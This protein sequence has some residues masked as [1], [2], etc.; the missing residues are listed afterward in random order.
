M[1]G[2]RISEVGGSDRSGTQQRVWERQKK[3]VVIG[4]ISTEENYTYNCFFPWGQCLCNI[5]L[6]NG[7]TCVESFKI[8]RVKIGSLGDEIPQKLTHICNYT[9]GA[10]MF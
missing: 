5:S 2:T 9:T 8:W 4:L 10:S 7:S 1:G 3:I 6:L